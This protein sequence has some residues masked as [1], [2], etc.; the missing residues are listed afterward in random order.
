MS[1]GRP[2][3]R[4]G[5]PGQVAETSTAPSTS[6]ALKEDQE[7]LAVRGW[8]F[9]IVGV[10]TASSAVL[11]G[12]NWL[13][14]ALFEPSAIGLG[15]NALLH[16]KEPALVVLLFSFGRLLFVKGNWWLMEGERR[17]L[18]RYNAQLLGELLDEVSPKEMLELLYHEPHRFQQE[19]RNTRI[20][21][22][23]ASEKPPA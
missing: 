12:L 9:I 19:P 18:W 20:M 2:E 22:R 21:R 3:K 10:T 5:N 17:S 8:I 16:L 1:D 6:Q 14:A 15:G 11:L 13:S 23:P 4:G 7:R